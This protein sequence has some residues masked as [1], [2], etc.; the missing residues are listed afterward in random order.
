[1]KVSLK[2]LHLLAIGMIAFSIN[3][4]AQSEFSKSSISIGMVVEDL[5]QSLRFYQ[6]VV[7]MVKVRTFKVES[8]KAVRMGL[9]IGEAFDITVLKLENSEEAAEL[10][11][12]TFKKNTPHKNEQFIPDA[13]G[14]RYLTIFVKSMSPLLK[15]IEQSGVKTLGKTPTM[16]DETRQFVLI[17]DPDGNFVEFIGPG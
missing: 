10:K 2:S 11:L 8:D 6:E 3:T 5:E 12:M 13:N 14:I 17:Q 9:S 16:L 7:G 15:R 4:A 1:M